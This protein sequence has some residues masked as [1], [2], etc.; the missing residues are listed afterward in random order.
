MAQLTKKDVQEIVDSSID[1]AVERF[2][3]IVK[4]GFDSV[5]DRFKGIDQR[6]DQ[7][8]NRL[9]KVDQRLDHLERDMSEVKYLLT[10]VVRRDEFLEL[11][12]RLEALEQKVG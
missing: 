11:K 10:D 9:D 3:G 7:I 5:D 4:V 8:D 2:V 12:Q 6:L 1:K